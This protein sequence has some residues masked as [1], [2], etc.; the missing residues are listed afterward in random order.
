MQNEQW[1]ADRAFGAS[2]TI[3]LNGLSLS[4]PPPLVALL[5]LSKN[6]SNASG[7]RL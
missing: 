7:K 2:F 6:G 3:I 5:A 1:I 4:L